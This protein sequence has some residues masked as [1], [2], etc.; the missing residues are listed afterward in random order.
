MHQVLNIAISFSNVIISLGMSQ[1]FYTPRLVDVLYIS[2]FL[3]GKMKTK[4]NNGWGMQ[5]N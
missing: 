2:I 1:S 3:L 4:V 5:N